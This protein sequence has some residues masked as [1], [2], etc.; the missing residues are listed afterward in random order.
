MMLKWKQVK[1]DRFGNTEW[2]LYAG[3]I[4][5]ASAWYSNLSSRTEEK[6]YMSQT[7]VGRNS[8]ASRRFLTIEEAKIAAEEQLHSIFKMMGIGITI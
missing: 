5:L 3:T 2:R 4:E 7:Y 1:V 8:I 6:N